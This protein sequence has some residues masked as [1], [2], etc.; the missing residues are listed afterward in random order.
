MLFQNAIMHYNIFKHIV[1][2]HKLTLTFQSELLT[3]FS[4]LRFTQLPKH[5]F[6]YYSPSDLTLSIDLAHEQM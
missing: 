6:L 1:S 4:P 2:G 3:Y 5:A